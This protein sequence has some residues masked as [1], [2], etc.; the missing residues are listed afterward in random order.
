MSRYLLALLAL[1]L[2]F[3]PAAFAADDDGDGVDNTIDVCCQTPP[4]V[5]V[6]ANGRPYG[7]IDLDCDVDQ[8]DFAMFQLSYTGPLEPCDTELCENGVD[9]DGDSF[10]DCDDFDCEFDPACIDEICDNDID[11]DGDSF[12][13][14][15]DFD[16][17][18]DPACIDEICNN[19][20]DDD[21]DS[22]ID[23]DDFECTNDPNCIDEICNNDIDDDGDS[24]IDCDDF[25]CLD[26]PACD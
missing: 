13:D 22:F 4:N 26:H 7:D 8:L 2:L 14:C 10:I 18:F 23:C 5:P 15:D 19:D 12:I 11:D 21:G 16:C 1:G 25:E 6:D 24:F 17:E 20:I 3:A 9:D